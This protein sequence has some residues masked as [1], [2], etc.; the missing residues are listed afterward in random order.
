[1]ECKGKENYRTEERRL[2]ERKRELKDVKGRRTGKR[3]N[4]WR[5]KSREAKITKRC[6]VKSTRDK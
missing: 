5:G 1:M 3:I 4:E 6:T 2:K